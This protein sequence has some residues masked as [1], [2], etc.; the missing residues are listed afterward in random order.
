MDLITP[1]QPLIGRPVRL[2]TGF[3]VVNA[4]WNVL[5][6]K[7][8]PFVRMTGHARL[9]RTR[10]PPHHRPEILLVRRVTVAALHRVFQDRM[11]IGLQ[12]IRPG[13]LVAADTKGHFLGL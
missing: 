8:T 2:M 10:R 11:V 12:E 6:H 7:R 13:R 4:N 9:R 5:E 1:Q 3:T